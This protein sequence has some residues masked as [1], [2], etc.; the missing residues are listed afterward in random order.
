MKK[1]NDDI[2]IDML[3]VVVGHLLGDFCGFVP[4]DHLGSSL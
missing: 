2:C 1:L 4:F 3:V